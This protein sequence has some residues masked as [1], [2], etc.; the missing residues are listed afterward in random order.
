M[1]VESVLLER[2]PSGIPARL[3]GA[4]HF[5][6]RWPVI[7]LFVLSILA[8][9]GIFGPLFAPHDPVIASIGD[10][11]VP[12]AWTGEGNMNHILGTDHVG[13]DILSRLIYGAR[14]SLMVAAIAVSSGFVIGITIGMVSG[15]LGGLA[16]EIIIRIVDI[17][18]ALPFLMIALVVVF[19]FGQNLKVLLVL[20]ALLSWSGFVRIIR[21]QTLQLKTMDY[22]ALARV[23]GASPFRIILRHIFP[24]VVNSAI[25]IATLNVGGL[26]LAEATLSFLGAGIPPPTSAWGVMVAEGRD[27][28]ASAWWQVVF[29]GAAIF[30]TLMSLNFLG[31]WVRDRLDPRLRQ[32]D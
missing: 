23:A 21:A 12:P 9:A 29:P 20:L 25:V 11:H 16:D 31:D 14:I 28:S 7:P 5:I 1:A 26:I 13:R 17:W 15:Y 6:R 22:V 27:Y 10:R 24:G 2:R 30:M 32:L 3:G 4:W 18:Y 19:I 8:I